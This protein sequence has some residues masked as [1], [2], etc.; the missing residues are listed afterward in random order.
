MIF[1]NM[2]K[3][4][5]HDVKDCCFIKGNPMYQVKMT[6]FKIRVE[7]NKLREMIKYLKIYTLFL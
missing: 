6:S 7:Q 3:E 5:L 2:F 1:F 4:I